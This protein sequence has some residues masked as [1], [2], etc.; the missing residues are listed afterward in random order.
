MILKRYGNPGKK[1]D[2][3]QVG[4][5]FYYL[6]TGH[7]P[8]YADAPNT[9]PSNIRS[10]YRIYDAVIRKSLT[11]DKNDRYGEIREMIQDLDALLRSLQS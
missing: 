2:I 5:I 9:L 6:I 4:A 11:T 1:T 3:Y 7:I 8:V 10:D